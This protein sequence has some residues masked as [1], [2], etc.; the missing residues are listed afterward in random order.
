MFSTAQHVLMGAHVGGL[1][2]HQGIDVASAA[3][4]P[5]AKSVKMAGKVFFFA[6]SPLAPSTTM[7]SAS[8]S[9]GRTTSAIL[10]RKKLCGSARCAAAALAY[11]AGI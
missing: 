10:H 1:E 3:A 11:R 5:R 8:M 4:H 6:R 9:C 2:M 7:E